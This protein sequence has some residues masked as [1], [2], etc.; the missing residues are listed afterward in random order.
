MVGGVVRAHWQ[1]RTQFL[2][3]G[4][5][6]YVANLRIEVLDVVVVQQQ[7]LPAAPRVSA[8]VGVAVLGGDASPPPLRAEPRSS[9]RRFPFCGAA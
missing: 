2:Q 5:A 1:A 8:C 9:T 7:R 3:E 6:R 4:Q